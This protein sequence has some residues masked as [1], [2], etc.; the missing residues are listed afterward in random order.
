MSNE[1]EKKRPKFEWRCCSKT[2]AELINVWRKKNGI[3]ERTLGENDTDRKF[4][5]RPKVSSRVLYNNAVG[6]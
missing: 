6:F 2:F 3:Y 4:E 5:R 1:K